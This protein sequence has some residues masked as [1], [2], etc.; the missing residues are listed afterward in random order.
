[1]R[2]LTTPTHLLLAVWLGWVSPCWAQQGFPSRPIQL[3][4]GAEPGGPLDGLAR[5]LADH[6]GKEL[7]QPVVVDNRPGAGGTLAAEALRRSAPDGHS[8]MVSWLGNATAQALMPR[9]SFDITRDFAH[10]TQLVEGAA[11]LVAHPSTGFRTLGDVLARARQ[12]PGGLSYASAGNGSSGHLA[13]ELLKQRAHVSL[14]HIPYRGGASGLNDVIQGRVDL[15]FINQD[16]VIPHLPS[17]RLVPLAISS[18]QRNPLFPSLPTV[19]ESGFVGFEAVTWA[20]LSAPKGTPAPVIGRL[21]GATRRALA[22]P[23]HARQA[24]QG[25]QVIGTSPAQFSDFVQDEVAKW[26]RVIQSAHIKP[27]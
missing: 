8:L 27:D 1:M 15:M 11:V 13:M 23:M 26:T 2:Y 18:A 3:I 9:V 16:A 20:G 25:A 14:V 5:Q 19:A 12:Q 7:G 10:V 21:L 22:G 17:G 6:L 4:V 24:A